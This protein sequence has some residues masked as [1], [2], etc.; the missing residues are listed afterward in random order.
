MLS[1]H[2]YYGLSSMDSSV[3]HTIDNTM[4]ITH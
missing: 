4:E 2:F 3:V 1:Y